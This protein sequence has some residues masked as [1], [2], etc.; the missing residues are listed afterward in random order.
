MLSTVDLRQNIN[1]Y[2]AHYNTA[3]DLRGLLLPSK[4]ALLDVCGWI[5][6]AMDSVVIDSANRC[7]LSGTRVEKIRSHY[8]KNTSGFKYDNHF[9]KMLTAVTGFKVLE[10]AEAQMGATTLTPFTATLSSLIKLRNHYA[11]THLNIA[12]PYPDSVTQIPAPSG[13]VPYVNQA[14]AALVALENALISLNY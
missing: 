8:V 4:S 10:Q 9:E 11:H 6:E 1:V 2:Q 14:E 12:Q 5:E 3:S 7:S 13:L